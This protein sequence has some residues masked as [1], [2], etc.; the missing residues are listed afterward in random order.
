MKKY[1]FRLWDKENKEF[2][3]DELDIDYFIN[4]DGE[5]C[6]FKYYDLG[7]FEQD[8]SMRTLDNVEISQYTVQLDDFKNE[9]YEGDIIIEPSEDGD[10]YLKLI[11]FGDD[12]KDYT[13][14]LKGFKI[15]KGIP[16]DLYYD[17]S[18]R[19]YK[20]KHSYLIK[21]YNIKIDDDFFENWISYQVIGNKYENE[22]LYKLVMYG[23]Q[24]GGR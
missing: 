4:M 23:G 6:R 20:G 9:I 10:Y 12:E 19:V 22:E 15:I 21:D 11:G 17:E 13:S 16:L 24:C 2:L 7:S 18:K 14:I 1:K 3:E 5:I 8:F